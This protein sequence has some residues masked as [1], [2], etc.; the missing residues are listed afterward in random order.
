MFLFFCDVIPTFD[1]RGALFPTRQQPSPFGWI[2]SSIIPRMQSGT[3]KPQQQPR[4]LQ[5]IMAIRDTSSP[6]VPAATKGFSPPLH[7]HTRRVSCGAE[8][9]RSFSPDWR[10]DIA[11][12]R[13]GSLGAVHKG[14]TS[15]YLFIFQL[16]CRLNKC[17][18][19]SWM[20]SDIQEVLPKNKLTAWLS[21]RIKTCLSNSEIC[22]A[23][24][25]M[26]MSLKST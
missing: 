12:D 23:F 20:P 10:K 4:A 18:A 15:V 3:P 14:K 17:P 22:G 13:H 5:V 7:E 2:I 24:K 19:S 26:K 21:L 11:C 16:A 6:W 8:T 25:W 1:H 9:C